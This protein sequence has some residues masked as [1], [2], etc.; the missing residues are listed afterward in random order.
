MR[1]CRLNCRLLSKRSRSIRA[2]ANS[3]RR[4]FSASISHTGARPEG[5]ATGCPLRTFMTQLV[6]LPLGTGMR[7]AIWP[8]RC[9]IPSY[10]RG[11]VLGTVRNAEPDRRDRWPGRTVAR[12]PEAPFHMA[13]QA[14][15]GS[16]LRSMARER[17]GVEGAGAVRV[18]VRY[19]LAR[20]RVDQGRLPKVAACP[21]P[22]WQVHRKSQ[23]SISLVPVPRS[24]V[25]SSL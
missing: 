2:L 1:F 7:R 25:Q 6:R 15:G 16:P 10:H 24:P 14:L 23:F 19:T 12:E 5:A 9:A 11:P 20:N 18:S 4:A 17:P 22:F 3:R 8:V 13:R 21:A